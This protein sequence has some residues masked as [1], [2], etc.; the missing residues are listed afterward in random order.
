M[1]NMPFPMRHDAAVTS[2]L[3]NCVQDGALMY[4]TLTYGANLLGWMGGRAD[5]FKTAEYFTGRAIQAVRERIAS[6]AAAS[7][8]V[9]NSHLAI[10]IYSLAISELWKSMPLMQHQGSNHAASS[11]TTK[12]KQQAPM[13]RMHLRALLE[14]VDSSGGWSAFDPYVI[15]S[16]IL[17]DKYLA[18]WEW[19]P[20]LIA[21]KSLPLEVNFEIPDMNQESVLLGSKLLCADDPELK[22]ILKKSIKFTCFARKSWALAPLP[23]DVQT[24]LF[25]Q[26]Q[27]LLY[28]LLNLV[29]LGS[30]DN[31]VRITTLIFL[32]TNMHY[33]G[34]QVC[35]AI[36]TTQLRAAL[37][38]AK[39]WED[40]FDSELRYWCLCS[41]LLLTEHSPN[42]AWFGAAL[43]KYSNTIARNSSL[44]IHIRNCFESYLYL[45]DRQGKQLASLVETLTAL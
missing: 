30:V 29:H 18:C 13:A 34:S 22:N 40:E 8:R 25:F 7:A 26:L 33:R 6:P 31:C 1:Q 14:L 36:L 16:A 12:A 20:P 21:I 42:E 9:A 41:A 17:A 35:A 24:G 38:D 11:S 15:E 32:Q 27:R 44:F 28:E 3:Q 37:I 43:R 39:F 19:T 23:F 4:S 5:T 10:S 2:R 45:D